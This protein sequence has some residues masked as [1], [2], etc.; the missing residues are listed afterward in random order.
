MNNH[1]NGKE[2]IG[3]YPILTDNTSYFIAADFD[4][5]EW[6]ADSQKFVAECTKVSLQAYTEISR[7]GNGAHVWIFFENT[8]PC[9]KSRAMILEVVRKT[10][11]YSEFSKEI[12]FDRLF[13]NQDTI[14]DG[15]FGNLIALPLQGERVAHGTSIF[16]DTTFT[17]YADQW[18]F[19]K[20]IHKHTNQELDSAYDIVIAKNTEVKNNKQ[21]SSGIQI[22]N[23]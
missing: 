4:E 11:N 7:S 21:S 9:W 23:T 6:K 14:T 15:G 8:Y 19:L 13:P 12:S 1:L 3:I 17:P 16:C 10:F 18:G 2:T 5:A 20:T 22:M